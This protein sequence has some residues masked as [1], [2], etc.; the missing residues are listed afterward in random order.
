MGELEAR[1]RWPRA[2][3]EA[4]QLERLNAV[5]GHAVTH[6]PYYRRLRAERGLPAGFASLAEYRAAVPVLNKDEVKA[7]RH[8][9]LSERAGRGRW[10]RTSGSTGM[11]MIFFWGKAAHREMLRAKYRACAAWGIDIFDRTAYVW[12]GGAAMV[13][14]WEG[15]LARL[16]KPVLDRMRN[17][18]RFS[19]YDLGGKALRSILAEL[20]R[21]RPA[22]LY[23]FSRAVYMLALE[24][25]ASGFTCD[26]LRLVSL[27]AEPA[28]PPMIRTVEKV[29]GVPAVMEYGATECGMIACEGPDRSMRVREDLFFLETLPRPDGRYDIVLSVLFNP[30]FP[31]LRYGIE[32]V[33]DAALDAPP[34]GFA[35]LRNIAGRNSDVLLSRNGRCIH[36][37]RIDALFEFE[38]PKGIRRYRVHQNADGALDVAVE[39]D[40]PARPA[41]VRKIEQTLHDLVEGYPVRLEFVS[42][43]P[44]T[45]AGKHRLVTSELTSGGQPASSGGAR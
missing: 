11:P 13:P 38:L 30:S 14:G 34:E 27:T 40:G 6:V 8:D 1:E 19:A 10:D 21:F 35:V 9:F 26:A 37:A 22:L 17:R 36:P 45:A 18:R 24:A 16:R 44:Q 12:G 32:D 41:D 28:F 43:V 7:R 3:I 29:F 33:T 20:G 2:A 31:L 23:G 4:W 42:Q 39:L 5:W 25:Q 15:W